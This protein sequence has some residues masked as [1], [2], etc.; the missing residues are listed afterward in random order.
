MPEKEAAQFILGS[1]SPDAVHY[2]PAFMGDGK[3]QIGPT[4][5]TSHLC[6]I[7]E[8]RWG[9][10]TDNTGWEKL[11][12]VFLDE[13]PHDPFAAG[14]ATHAL[15]DLHN[16]CTLWYKFRTNHPA[17]AAKG[18]ASDYYNDLRA[19]DSRLYFEHPATEEIM[20]LLST[21]NPQRMSDLVTKEETH[22]IQQNI[23]DEHFA[24]AVLNENHNYLFTTY[25]DT[26]EFI[27]TAADFCAKILALC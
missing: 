21:A 2:R 13:H 25:N 23:L 5:K 10:V 11:I 12:R 7:S 4:K 19:I 24:N 20:S 26:L 22:A 9:H 16:N 18:Y 27:S 14:Y 1:I 6:P 8:E 17:E 15:T 3:N